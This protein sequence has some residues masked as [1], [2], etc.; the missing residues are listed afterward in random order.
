MTVCKS[1]TVY[2]CRSSFPSLIQLHLSSLA[3]GRSVRLTNYQLVHVCVRMCVFLSMFVH[4]RRNNAIQGI[5]SVLACSALTV[6]WDIKIL[7][8]V[9]S[10]KPV[11]VATVNDFLFLR[12]QYAKEVYA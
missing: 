8:T 5:H 4:A 12:N 1:A 7:I 2:V 10:T 6:A 3:M 9:L 11:N